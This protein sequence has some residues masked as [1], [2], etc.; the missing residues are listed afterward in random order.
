MQVRSVRA[1]DEVQ[2]GGGGQVLPS[3]PL[4]PASGEPRGESRTGVLH[5]DWYV[6]RDS[7]GSFTVK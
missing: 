6:F 2:H 5:R 7:S 1:D 3:L 4:A